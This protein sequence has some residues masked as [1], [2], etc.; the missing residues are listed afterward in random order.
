MKVIAKIRSNPEAVKSSLLS[1]LQLK[2][3][4]SYDEAS[5]S[6]VLTI[7]EREIGMAFLSKLRTFLSSAGVEEEVSSLF[8]DLEQKLGSRVFEARASI[9]NGSLVIDREFLSQFSN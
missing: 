1:L 4:A 6:L 2:I 3:P 7:S 9:K 5:S 8:F